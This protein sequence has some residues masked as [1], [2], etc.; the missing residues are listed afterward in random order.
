MAEESLGFLASPLWGS[1]ALPWEGDDALDDAI[2]SFPADGD[3]AFVLGT[4]GGVQLLRCLDATHAPPCALC[5]PAPEDPSTVE[6]RGDGGRKNGEKRLRY[7]LCRTVEWL[8]ARHRA[9]AVTALGSAPEHAKLVSA[10][11]N[12][13]SVELRKA[14][15]LLLCRLWGLQSDIWRSKLLGRGAQRAPQPSS[16]VLALPL[17]AAAAPSSQLSSQAEAH[18]LARL[19]AQA[20]GDTSSTAQLLALHSSSPP[21]VQ[22]GLTEVLRRKMTRCRLAREA[23]ERVTQSL[24]GHHAAVQAELAVLSLQAGAQPAWLS[25][26]GR[27]EELDKVLKTLRGLCECAVGPFH[28]TPA[29]STAVLLEEV[30]V[31]EQA[32]VAAAG[33]LAV[34]HPSPPP[35][36]SQHRTDP[37]I[38]LGGQHAL[39]LLTHVNSTLSL[40]KHDSYARFL[41]ATASLASLLIAHT[42]AVAEGFERHER[43]LEVELGQHPPAAHA[44]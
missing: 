5:T 43:A 7:Q 33:E 25:L 36:P 6:L 17:A 3:P 9:E 14:D 22:P 24:R 38:R 40:A 34:V 1:E 31:G 29:P 32:Q 13:H 10:L 21:H 27:E 15:L 2:N 18:S 11:R 23:T 8:S 39:H 20:F 30:P 35:T 28:C 4:T 41:D 12:R 44:H 26:V 19:S 16:R 42:T 37:C